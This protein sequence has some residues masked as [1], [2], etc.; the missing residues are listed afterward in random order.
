MTKLLA[1]FVL[2]TIAGG[3]CAV[4]RPQAVPPAPAPTAQNTILTAGHAVAVLVAARNGDALFARFAPNMAAV[5]PRAKAAAFAASL[6]KY[7]APRD[8]W[9][10]G[11]TYHARLAAPDGTD[12]LL[13]VVFN[14]AKIAGFTVLP[15]PSLT[16]TV[17]D[18]VRNA[19]RLA[20][21]QIGAGEASALHARFAPPFAATVSEAQTR[22][23]LTQAAPIPMPNAHPTTDA[24]IGGAN[25]GTWAYRAVFAATPTQTT[26]A[27]IVFT[28]GAARQIAGCIVHALP[29]D[30]LPSDP[31]AGYALKTALRLPFAPG[32]AWTVFWGGD[33]RSQN[34]HIDAPD[35]RHAYD[36]VITQSGATHTGAGRENADYFAWN[37]PILAP[38]PGTVIAV[39]NDIPDNTPGTMRPEV[40]LGNF[41]LLDF[42]NHEYGVL[43]HL[44]RG[45][46]AVKPGQTVR[47]GDP[48]GKCG[49]SGNSSEPHL[50]FHV[51]DT[52]R[53]LA[54]AHGLPAPFTRLPRKRQKRFA[55]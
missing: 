2:L 41:V 1:V 42:G 9:T 18:A 35:Q 54:D 49:N 46:V 13:A 24:V 11:E 23:L 26:E 7:A 20:V 17:R 6:P 15:T 4:M 55:W 31:R 43:A 36:F 5:L 48:L 28:D 30:A 19:G 40:A 16:N 27:V 14:G 25:D 10:T 34:R 21:S 22:A 37:R 38:A 51:Q 47:T 32:E 45:T 33:T 39:R 29:P 50:H 8:E 53:L 52:P 3:A 44:R 12:A